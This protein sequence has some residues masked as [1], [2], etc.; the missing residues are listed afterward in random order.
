M[1][2]EVFD[3]VE[4]VGFVIGDRIFRNWPELV[5]P[6]RE[7]YIHF[8]IRSLA[9]DKTISAINAK[10]LLEVSAPFQ[11][12]RIFLRISRRSDREA[13]L[14]DAPLI[15]SVASKTCVPWFFGQ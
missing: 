14:R 2:V 6:D 7:E 4:K 12:E 13:S 8:R 11:I 5:F 10:S 1:L 3:H 15:R 9:R